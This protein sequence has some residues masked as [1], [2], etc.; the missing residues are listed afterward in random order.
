ME[1]PKALTSKS[2][3]T[4]TD[5]RQYIRNKNRIKTNILSK[6]LSSLIFILFMIYIGGYFIV[7]INKETTAYTKLIY[8]SIDA[9]A[10]ID[11][12]II[13]DEVVYKTPQNGK[14]L[15]I[16]NDTDKVK[17]GTNICAIQNGEVASYIEND[18]SDIEQQIL[19][20]QERGDELSLAQ[21][22]AKRLNIQV[23]NTVNDS[24]Y[25]YTEND[26]N[27][28]YA[29]AENIEK[30]INLRNQMIFEEKRGSSKELTDKKE[31]AEA[32]LNANQ[33]FITTD[34]GGIVSYLVD[35]ME[36]VFTLDSMKNLTKE[37]INNK[38]NTS[39]FIANREVTKDDKVFKVIKSNEYYIAFYAPNAIIKD[40]EIDSKQTIYVDMD[41]RDVPLDVT[42]FD[43]RK[44]DEESYVILKSNKQMLDFLDSRN[45]KFKTSDSVFT[46]LKIPKTSIID[47][48]L[49][50]IPV[51]YLG[52]DLVK[53]VKRKNTNGSVE[54][55]SVNVWKSDNK[56]IWVFQDFNSLHIEDVLVDRN[57]KN[58][59]VLKEIENVKGLFKI[60][61]G[62]AQFYKIEMNDDITDL[63]GY[64]IIDPEKNPTIKVHDI[65]VTDARDIEEGQMVYKKQ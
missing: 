55:V 4:T 33:T 3:K 45:I 47:K 23:K 7:Y 1:K 14:I 59:F 6:L 51:E 32:M 19:K 39:D 43:I 53:T 38:I 2:K 44:G 15:Y 25:E 24:I 42:V 5:F 64:V 26:I 12:T 27:G 62:I 13:R 28:L 58:D 56:H 10:I 34:V 52:A 16:V 63:N 11:G 31:D 20:L 60:N 50:K 40:F 46:G 35:G 65:I 57:G 36:E 41:K 61:N 9:P 21:K 54:V 18:I 49:F 22:D 30:K 29:F 17:S 48:T 8:G 37:H